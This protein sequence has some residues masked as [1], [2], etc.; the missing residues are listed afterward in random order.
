MNRSIGSLLVAAAMALP[1]LPAAAQDGGIDFRKMSPAQREAFGEAVRGYLLENPEV[2]YDAIRILE[3]RR[4]AAA[5]NADRDLVMANADALFD[6]GFSW[7][8]GNPEGDVT[9]VEFSDYRC[10]YCKRAHPHVKAVLDADPNVRLIVKEFPI[11]GPDSVAAARVAMAAHDVDPDKYGS[12][13]NALMEFR[14]NL[15]EAVAYRLAADAGYD[16]K[17]LKDRAASDEVTA[18]ITANHALADALG[19][20]GTPSFVIGGQ[21]VR[22]YIEADAMMAAI[23]QARATAAN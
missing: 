2:I 8:G 9:I 23:G 13:N 21:I 15:T 18:R 20:Q 16:I 5:A 6:D 19:I 11:L 7:V 22:G 12:L 10:G 17:E 1:A 14:G 4:N 3:Q